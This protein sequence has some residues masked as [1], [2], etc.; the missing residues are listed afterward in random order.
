MGAILI[1]LQEQ[2]HVE[3][4]AVAFYPTTFAASLLV[5]GLAGERLTARWGHQLVLRT[6]VLSM[7]GGAGLLTTSSWP[8]TLTGALLL[9]AGGALTVQI[10]PAGLH[11]HHGKRAPAALAEAS[12]LSSFASLLAP[13]A[14]ATAIATGVGWQAGYLVVLPLALLLIGV[15]KVPWKPSSA[16]SS[17]P[18]EHP[19]LPAAGSLLQRCIDVLLAI[20]IEFCL[21]LWSADAFTQW[22]HVSAAQ[23][24]ALA[25]LFVLGMA[26]TRAAATPLT[27]R[28]S[29]RAV[30]LG[31]C[32]TASLGFLLF[33]A[34][35]ALVLSAVGLFLAG[36]GVALLYPLALARVVQA[37]PEAPDHA[38]ARA[39]LASGLAIGLAPLTL[40]VIGDQ[41]GQRVGYLLVPALLAAL[42]LRTARDS[43]QHHVQDSAR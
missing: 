28:C 8:L 30:M 26:I 11:V 37:S 22:H 31:A 39:A 17:P 20:G 23:A 13:L 4:A 14:V 36:L 29:P 33:W 24:P 42:A 9:G 1:P 18:D 10:V 43:A 5:V 40:A 15:A 3:R 25:A 27:A 32:A 2:L 7:A 38:A 21:M 35:P 41:I 6:A 19:P 16:P 12:A 34:A